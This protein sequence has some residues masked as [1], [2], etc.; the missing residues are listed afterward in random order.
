MHRVRFCEFCGQLLGLPEGVGEDLCSCPADPQQREMF[1]PQD[2]H[3]QGA[4]KCPGCGVFFVGEPG[5]VACLRCSNAFGM[6]PED[7]DD[8]PYIWDLED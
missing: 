1:S 6:I 3:P 5:Q 8:R 7:P 4:T 2:L